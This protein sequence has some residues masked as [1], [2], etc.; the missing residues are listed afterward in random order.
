MKAL[1][2]KEE[3]SPGHQFLPPKLLLWT[4]IHNISLEPHSLGSTTTNATWLFKDVVKA[5]TVVASWD[6]HS[7]WWKTECLLGKIT[8]MKQDCLVPKSCPVLLQPHG[9]Q[10]TRVLCPWD[11]PGKHCG[12]GH[13]FLLQGIFPTQDQTHVFCTGMWI[14]YWATRTAQSKIKHTKLTTSSIAYRIIWSNC[15]TLPTVF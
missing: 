8:S 12:V 13:H 10:S 3:R 5:R 14:L 7:Y 1:I 15:L 9:L 4:K 6:S 11:L 2:R